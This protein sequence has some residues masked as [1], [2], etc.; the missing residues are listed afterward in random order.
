MGR[1]SELNTLRDAEKVK[2]TDLPTDVLTRRGVESRSTRQ[3]IRLKKSRKKL[4]GGW[5]LK[6]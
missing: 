3:K 2:G 5:N 1:S 4:E 6:S